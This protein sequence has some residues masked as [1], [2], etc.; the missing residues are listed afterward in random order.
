MEIEYYERDNYG[1]T[2]KYIKD[3]EQAKYVRV[4]TNTKTIQ[5]YQMRALEKFGVS[6]VQVFAPKK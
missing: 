5:D 3:E 6:F 4:L 1:T 2:M